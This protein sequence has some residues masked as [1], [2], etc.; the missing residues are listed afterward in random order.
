MTE[1]ESR[2]DH[3]KLIYL[4]KCIHGAHADIALATK[5]YTILNAI[6]LAV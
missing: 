2:D 3:V 6:I 4:K 5:V 1:K